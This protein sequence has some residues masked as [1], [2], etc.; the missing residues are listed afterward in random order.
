MAADWSAAMRAPQLREAQAREDRLRHREDRSVGMRI[1]APLSMRAAEQRSPSR[2]D[3]PPNPRT[4]RTTPTS[5]Q[6]TLSR[7]ELSPVPLGGQ[8]NRPSSAGTLLRLGSGGG[9]VRVQ[10]V[11]ELTDPLD[12]IGLADTSGTVTESDE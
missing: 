10:L 7:P 1:F 2:W 4:P 8:R 9:Q 5:A 12:L 3:A 6:N 11:E